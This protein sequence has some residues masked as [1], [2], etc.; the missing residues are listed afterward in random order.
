MY[1]TKIYINNN[2]CPQFRFLNYVV[3]VAAREKKINRYKI[4]TGI[5]HVQKEED[6][7]FVEIGHVLDIENLKIPIPCRKYNPRN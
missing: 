4:P 3:H 5:I 2:F 6:G 1:D 7:S